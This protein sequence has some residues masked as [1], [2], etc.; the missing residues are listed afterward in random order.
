MQEE[1]THRGNSVSNA[2]VLRG[3]GRHQLKSLTNVTVQENL[4]V[5]CSDTAV[6][7]LTATLSPRWEIPDGPSHGDRCLSTASQKFQP[8]ISSGFFA[9]E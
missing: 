1:K 5:N 7:P 2:R 9:A 4:A 3:E 6:T 8:A